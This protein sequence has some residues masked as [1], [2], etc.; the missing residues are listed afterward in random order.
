LKAAA[1]VKIDDKVL[2]SLQVPQGTTGA[3]PIMS[4]H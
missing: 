2:E 1:N 4:G 3:E